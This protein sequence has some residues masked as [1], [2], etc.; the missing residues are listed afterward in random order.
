[1]AN[2]PL[3]RWETSTST[4]S[5]FDVLDGIRGLAI[6]LVVSFHSLYTNPTHGELAR[7]AGY[8][9]SAGWMGVPVFF[10]LSGFLIS[11][12][13]FQRR[14]THPQA[15]Y[16]PGYARRRMGK[17]LPPF[18][19]SII[20][21]IAFYWWQFDDVAYLKS[22][23]Q[24]ATGISYFKLMPTSPL[25]N[26]AYWSLYL[27][28]LFYL[29]LPFMFWLLRGRTVQTTTTILFLTIFCLAAVARH[30]AW[31]PNMWTLPGLENINLHRMLWQ[32]FS[33]FP[34]QMDYFAWGIAF[35][36]IYVVLK[37][38]REHVRVLGLFGYV[39]T[40][41]LLATLV[42]W[43]SWVDHYNLAAKPTRWSV[44]VSHLLPGLATML[45]LFFVY[46]SQSLGARIFS[47][48]PLRFTGIISY[49]WFLFHLPVVS[50]FQDHYE[51]P[52]GSILAF[53]WRTIVPLVITYG[54]A[55]LVYRYFSLPILHRI[56]DRLKREAI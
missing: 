33:R 56:R 12:P 9:I 45:M 34:C 10:V 14:A 37:P 17:I 6:L 15:W 16:V 32:E 2:T 8:I 41:L 52:H 39:G 44:E 40:A 29:T 5:H 23:W 49:E 27:E 48:Q 42:L 22:A 18:Y 19:L 3:K 53:V 24:L 13:F 31:L 20:I 28:S 11:Y 4:G 36:G 38:V 35:S 21:F 47:F 50:W 55:V 26:A 51:R 30:C 46:D 1:M 25:F 7:V 54:L 43:G